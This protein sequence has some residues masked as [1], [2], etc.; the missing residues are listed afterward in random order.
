M[1]GFKNFQFYNFKGGLDFKNSPPLIEQ[2]EKKSAWADGYNVELL[3]NGGITKMQGSQLL[4]SMPEDIKDEIIG[5]FEG[6]QNGNKFLVIETKNGKFYQVS[7]D[8]FVL[9]KEGLSVG[10]KPNFKVYL[11]GVFVSNGFDEPFL[12]VPDKEEEIFSANAT[13]SGGHNIR[14]KA[15][16]VF[17]GRIWIADNSTL[18]YSALGKYNDWTSENDAGSISNFHNDTSPITALCCYKDALVIHKKDSSF[19]LTGNSPENF[20]IQPFSNMGSV[21]PFGI[22]IADGRHLFFNRQI[23]PFLVNELGEI[24]QGSAVSLIVESKLN[25]FVDFKNEN[26]MLLNYKNKSQIWCFIYKSNQDYFREI[27]IYDY[28]NNAWFLRKV[29][30]DISA[31]WEFDGMIYSA[32]K[33]G[34]I[35][36]EAVGSSFLGEPVDFMWASPFFH[37]GRVNACKTVEECALVL[38]TV[39]DNNFKFQVKKDYSSYEIFDKESFSNI[40]SNTLV[41][42][43]KNGDLGQGVLDGESES[44]RYGYVALPAVKVEN[45]LTNITGSNKSIQIQLLG[46]ESYHSLAL[47]GVEFREVYF[48]A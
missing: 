37:F 32:T 18:Y 43:D 19:I 22:N 24:V 35:V 44:E 31:A 5:G 15:I 6:E 42:Y 38:S 11:N 41:F 2:T 20:V 12:F 25:E 8:E 48:D 23:Y 21:S 40:A 10:A 39:K 14:G 36:K 30:Y 47:L 17:K 26:C 29:P 16:E 1:G 45:Y 9:K 13:T 46:N 27:L 7:G 28:I 34:A 4:V 3:D 33:D